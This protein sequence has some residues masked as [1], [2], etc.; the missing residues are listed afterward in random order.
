MNLMKAVEHK[1][2]ALH[3]DLDKGESVQVKRL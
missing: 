1:G 2:V 3:F